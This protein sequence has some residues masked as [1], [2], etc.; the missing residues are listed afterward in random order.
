M[1]FYG[2]I[3]GDIVSSRTI[4]PDTRQKLFED[5][6]QFLKGLKKK[7]ISRYE[8]FR[9]DSLQCQ[10][11]MPELSLRIA[12]IIRCYFRA[13]VPEEAKIKISP[14]KNKKKTPMK[15]YY[16]TDF[17]IRLAIGIGEVDF[18]KKDKISN[19]DGAAF[20]FSGETLDLMK[21]T[22]QK[23]AIMTMDKEL[24][25]Q[26]TPSILLLD[27]LIEKWTRNQAELVLYKLQDIKEEQIAAQLDISQSA[28]N[29]RTKTAQWYAIGKLLDYFEKTV[30]KRTL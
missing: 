3:T 4:E 24:D 19:S 29:Q 11:K 6:N 1:P 18:I 27:A 26:I 9:G 12:L 15:G 21:S 28:V 20:R 23:L 30:Q 22:S 2:I 17:D 25:E 8:T 16:T 14:K 10:A 13:Y 7:W 5:I